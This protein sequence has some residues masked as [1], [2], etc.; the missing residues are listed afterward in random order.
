MAAFEGQHAF[1]RG[2]RSRWMKSG[3]HG[4]RMAREPFLVGDGY[5]RIGEGS[6]STNMLAGSGVDEAWTTG[7]QLGDAVL[8][9]LRAGRRLYEGESGRDL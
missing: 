7:V 4:R 1:A 3:Q 5:A 2:A 9:L 8:E 6:G